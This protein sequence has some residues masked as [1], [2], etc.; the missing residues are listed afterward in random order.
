MSANPSFRVKKDLLPAFT[1]NDLGWKRSVQHQQQHRPTP[2]T[3]VLGLESLAKEGTREN[4][5]FLKTA[6]KTETMGAFSHPERRNT[7]PLSRR[8]QRGNQPQ[9]QRV[10]QKSRASCSSQLTINILDSSFPSA[11]LLLI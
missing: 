5:T 10:R 7:K 6:E 2:K 3:V 1:I 9:G 4:N 11:L 8:P